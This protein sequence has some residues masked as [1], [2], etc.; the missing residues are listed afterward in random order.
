MPK[1]YFHNNATLVVMNK[2]RDHKML[3]LFGGELKSLRT[4]NGFTIEKLAFDADIELNQVHRVE[5]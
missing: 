4:S 5:K 1:I 3:E 2:L